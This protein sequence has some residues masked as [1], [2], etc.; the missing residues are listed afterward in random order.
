MAE[1]PDKFDEYRELYEAQIREK[2]RLLQLA[3]SQTTN[4]KD[5]GHVTS[6]TSPGSV[7]ENE[8]FID[9]YSTQVPT[10]CDDMHTLRSGK[11]YPKPGISFDSVTTNTTGSQTHTGKTN[12]ATS[13]SQTMTSLNGGQQ[14]TSRTYKFLPAEGNVRPFTGQDKDYSVRTFLTMCEDVMRQ[15]GTTDDADKISFVRSKLAPGSRALNMMQSVTFLARNLGPNYDLFK[16]KM[17]RVFGGGAETSLIKQISSVVDNIEHGLRTEEPWDASIPAGEEMESCMR[18]LK[19][20]GWGETPNGTTITFDN[21]SKFFEIFFLLFHV[22]GKARQAFQSL[23]YGPD[24]SFDALITAAESK[25]GEGKG[26]VASVATAGIEETPVESYAAVVGS[27]PKVCSYCNKIGHLERRCL[28]RKNDLKKTG[29][30]TSGSNL[31]AQSHH[32]SISVKPKT[33]MPTNTA[34]PPHTPRTS[35]KSHHYQSLPPNPPPQPPPYHA[36]RFPGSSYQASASYPLYF[37]LV[38]GYGRHSS[39]R[40]R[41]IAHVRSG[42][43]ARRVASPPAGEAARPTVTKP[44]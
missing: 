11:V 14:S 29:A 20:Q 4:E 34:F 25:L 3:E 19:E 31:P 5:V 18:A 17:L 7:G 39:D 27:H 1:K 13:T 12:I 15:S 30:G 28:K 22:R 6:P 40:C 8:R 26:G 41:Q 42:T 21:L 16:E 32:P 9:S 36:R 10:F 2:A 33:H 24:D 37:C 23:P 38:H 35:A 43:E 44:G